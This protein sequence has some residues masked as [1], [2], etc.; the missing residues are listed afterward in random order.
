[1]ICLKKTPYEVLQVSKNATEDE[2]K[3]AYRRLSKIYHPDM[4]PGDKEAEI[5]FKEVSESYETLKDPQKRKKLDM[6]LYNY[7]GHTTSTTVNSSA[8]DIFNSL[9]QDDIENHNKEREDYIKFLEDMEPKFNKYN[10]TLENEMSSALNSGWFLTTLDSFYDKKVRIKNELEDL[11][12]RAQAFDNFQEYYLEIIKKIETLYSKGL[13]G[14]DEY[15]NSSNRTK[16]DPEVFIN[17]KHSIEDIIH[18]LELKRLDK[19]AYLKQELE[20]RNLNLYE[21]L[22]KRNL[23]QF[24]VSISNMGTILKSM[25]L[26]DEI[27]EFLDPYGITIEGFLKSKGRLL[28]DMKCRELLSIRDAI[29]N[30]IDSK[31]SV[32]LEDINLIDFEEGTTITSVKK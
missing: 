10:K 18:G 9:F 19:L 2:L 30:Y 31:K 4:N 6:D 16:Y 17:L 5:R 24:N 14:L 21:Y 29:K 15:L 8:Y 26:I 1:M 7:E 20:D 27:N 23:D 13:S 32:S 22:S 28:I 25:K 3:K 12:L 11:K